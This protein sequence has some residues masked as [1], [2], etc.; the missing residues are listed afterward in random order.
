[1]SVKW[2]GVTIDGGAVDFNGHSSAVHAGIAAR[3]TQQN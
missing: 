3:L 1:M 2:F